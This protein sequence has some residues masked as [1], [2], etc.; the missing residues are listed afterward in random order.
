M[1]KIF[2]L[3]N[4]QKK[5]DLFDE[6]FSRFVISTKNYL[7]TFVEIFI[8]ITSTK[9]DESSLFCLTQ[10]L[11][12]ESNNFNVIE[13]RDLNF[14]K[15]HDLL[16]KRELM[17]TKIDILRLRFQHDNLNIIII[18]AM[19]FQVAMTI[20]RRTQNIIMKFEL[21]SVATFVC[22]LSFLDSNF[23]LFET[24]IL[25]EKTFSRNFSINLKKMRLSSISRKFEKKRRFHRA[26]R[27][28]Q[29]LINRTDINSKKSKSD[30]YTNSYDVSESEEN[31]EKKKTNE[32]DNFF[33]IEVELNIEQ[34]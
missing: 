29:K 33:V 21:I 20:M 24:T 4:D 11:I 10:D 13:F 28:I 7:S 8:L 26:S 16:K 2:R 9:F 22:R 27:K 30:L 31:H 12:N 32:F 15:F 5:R 6:M 34:K 17:S 19:R 3:K 23:N 25:E 1:I 14:L 18:D